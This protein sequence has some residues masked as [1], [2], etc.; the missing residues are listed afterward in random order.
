MRGLRGFCGRQRGSVAT[1]ETGDGELGF[2]DGG[3]ETAKQGGL[4]VE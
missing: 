3:S 2:V 4:G 1:V